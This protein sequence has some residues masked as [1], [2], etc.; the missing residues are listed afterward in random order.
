M[1]DMCV[2]KGVCVCMF[3]SI[4]NF[5][6]DFVSFSMNKGMTCVRECACLFVKR[7]VQYSLRT[8]TALSFGHSTCVS[9]VTFSH[10]H[11][12]VRISIQ[13]VFWVAKQIWF[14]FHILDPTEFLLSFVELVSP[15]LVLM[16]TTYVV[17]NKCRH[18]EQCLC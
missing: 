15:W 17:L 8:T 14:L 6:G 1:Y 4:Q 16:A 2:M 9:Q 7:A 18:A 12:H 13:I 3:S 11:H 10:S 5:Q